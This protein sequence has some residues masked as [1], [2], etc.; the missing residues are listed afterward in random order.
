MEESTEY[1]WNGEVSLEDPEL[2]ELIQ[3]IE[4]IA[5][6]LKDV[7]YTPSSE[8]VYRARVTLGKGDVVVTATVQQDLL[9]LEIYIGELQATAENYATLLAHHREG[10]WWFRID[11]VTN[12]MAVVIRECKLHRRETPRLHRLILDGLMEYWTAQPLLEVL[13]GQ[14]DRT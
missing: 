1:E 5:G 6:L 9:S 12:G 7:Q 13:N 8:G 14:Y 4:P 3:A 10:P 11:G 2:L